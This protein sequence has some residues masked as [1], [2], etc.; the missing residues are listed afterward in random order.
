MKK[1][2]IAFLG[3]FLL[4]TTRVFSQA[5]NLD[6]TFDGDGKTL[7]SF[8]TLN[9]YG[10]SITVQPDGKILVAGYTK[11][12]DFTFDFAIARYNVDGSPDNTFD[13][14]GKVITDLSSGS[15]DNSKAIIV[16][17]NGKIL[18][19]G[20]S[21]INFGFDISLA[22]YNSDGS[23]DLTL[24]T[25]GIVTTAIGAYDD[26]ANAIAIQADGSILVAGSTSNGTSTD[27]A[28]VRY[29]ADGS[30]DNTFGTNGIVTTDFSGTDDAGYAV[31]VASD[32][33]ILVAGSTKIGGANSFALLR[34]NTNGTLDNTF[35]TNGSVTASFGGDD[36]AYGMVLQSDGKA[37]LAGTSITGGGNGQFALARFDTNGS[38]DNTFSSDGLA[39][40]AWGGSGVGYGVALQP[41]GK[42]LE[43]G[44][45]GD[46]PNQVF[47]VARLNADGSIDNSFSTDGK[48]TTDI[49]NGE[50]VANSIAMQPDGKIVV[51]GFSTDNNTFNFSI[52]RYLS[53]LNVGVIDFSW[54][55]NSVLIYPNPIENGV[56]LEYT[57][58]SNEKLSLELYDAGG[59]KVQSF[60]THEKRAVGL[61]HEVLNL[62]SMLPSGNYMLVLSN[63]RKQ[64]SIKIIKQ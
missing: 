34:Y 61:H 4:I 19:A 51:A 9:C 44:S 47:A 3:S 29:Q 59:R 15:D 28:V 55:E 46:N 2:S 38:S 26:I 33:K 45:S 60:F 36:V 27:I 13:G 57:L 18:V 10:K 41:D 35:N 30:L 56:Q 20:F 23:L 50:D 37:V 63:G 5:G 22:R 7:T 39:T 48:T 12:T 64:V 43:T 6:N 53:G 25:D 58:T 31:A 11:Q 8:N 40:V 42:I 14:N 54:N 21:L 32:G 1:I 17:A 16:D 62:D 52:V 24:G 49:G